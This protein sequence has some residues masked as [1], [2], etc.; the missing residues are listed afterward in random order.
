MGE[1]GKAQSEHAGAIPVAT[2]DTVDHPAERVSRVER[3]FVL[4]WAFMILL[5]APG[6]WD[7][8]RLDHPVVPPTVGRATSG[9]DEADGCVRQD[10]A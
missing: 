3:A 9:G 1:E 2:P 5:A 6:N 10:R 8:G 7:L 4:A